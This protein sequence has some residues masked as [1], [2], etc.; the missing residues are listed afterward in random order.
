MIKKSFKKNKKIILFIILLF[1]FFIIYLI[2]LQLNNTQKKT[3]QEKSDC[4]TEEKIVEVRGDSLSPFIEPGQKLKLL[5]DYYKCMPVKRDDIVSYDF[6]GNEI[7]VVKIVKGI[8]GDG[9]RLQKNGGCW[10]IL[11]NGKKVINSENKE[12]CINERS[13]R[14]L[15]LYEKDYKQKIPENAY[16]IL[17]DDISGSGST[18]FGLVDK[19]DFVG[20]L[21]II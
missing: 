21:V 12:Y 1:V 15:S 17:G 16:L 5:V 11:I 10:N 4:V 6:K 2:N 9:F 19:S 13:Y 7:P 8:E 3:I 20:K 14:L 18:V